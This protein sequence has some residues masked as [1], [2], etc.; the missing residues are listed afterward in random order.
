LGLGAGF[1]HLHDVV[2]R[3][4]ILLAGLDAMA[5]DEAG[6]VGGLTQ[7]EKAKYIRLYRR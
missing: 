3:K 4:I 1:D 5:E 6:P 7:V 2:Y